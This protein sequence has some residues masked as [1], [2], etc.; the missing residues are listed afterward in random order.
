MW[1]TPVIEKYITTALKNVLEKKFKAQH[2]VSK[3][4]PNFV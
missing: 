4:K 2:Q 3:V 1:P